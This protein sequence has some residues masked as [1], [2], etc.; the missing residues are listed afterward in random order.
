MSK[1]K[2]KKNDQ[3]PSQFINTID[4]ATRKKDG[5]YLL[6]LMEAITGSKPV[7]WGES[8]VGYDEYEMV[9]SS[10]SKAHWP[11]I[12]FSPRKQ[13]LSIYIMPG[14]KII[15]DLLPKLGKHKTSKACL[16]IN[17]LADIDMEVLKNIIERSITY[18]RDKYT[19]SR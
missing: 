9:Y 7:M 16:Y 4:H 8:I 13:N 2:T 3:P 19:V 18:M 11:M 12:G 15:D 10:G 6:E 17:K 5:L 14:F 1:V